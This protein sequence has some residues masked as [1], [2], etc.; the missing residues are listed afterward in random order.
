MP[1]GLDKFFGLLK[2]IAGQAQK[3]L[4]PL[5]A[6]TRHGNKQDAENL[7]VTFICWFLDLLQDYSRSGELLIW[8]Q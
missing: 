7:K 8:N 4:H 3:M 2:L 5:I 1:I 6:N